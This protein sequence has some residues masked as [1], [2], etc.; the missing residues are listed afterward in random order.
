MLADFIPLA[1][2]PILPGFMGLFKLGSPCWAAI[3]HFGMD[4]AEELVRGWRHVSLNH[5]DV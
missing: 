3:R 5:D 2:L 4:N 1:S